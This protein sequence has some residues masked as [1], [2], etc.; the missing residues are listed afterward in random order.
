MITFFLFFVI[1]VHIQS[2]YNNH[3][4]SLYNLHVLTSFKWFPLINI[5]W[6]ITSGNDRALR[7]RERKTEHF[8]AIVVTLSQW[9]SFNWTEIRL[10]IAMQSCR[11]SEF[12]TIIVMNHGEF[13]VSEW[14]CLLLSACEGMTVEHVSASG[15]MRQEIALQTQQ[16]QQHN[17][18][19]MISTYSPSKRANPCHQLKAGLFLTIE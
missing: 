10:R 9:I 12:T 16:Q 5:N 3:G 14:V 17:S 13:W 8:F 2:N 1:H 6:V 19:K 4:K 18:C 11:E 15:E 7:E